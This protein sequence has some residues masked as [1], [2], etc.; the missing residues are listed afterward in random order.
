MKNMKMLMVMMMMN[1]MGKGRKGHI[2]ISR[3]GTEGTATTRFHNPGV[4]IQ[5]VTGCDTRLNVEDRWTNGPIR[6]IPPDL[7]EDWSVDVSLKGIVW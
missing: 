5:E 3:D 2:Y 1:K 4:R 6:P 7:I